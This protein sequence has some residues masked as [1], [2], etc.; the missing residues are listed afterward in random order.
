MVTA[1]DEVMELEKGFW[2]ASA[3]PAF[4]Q[5]AMSDDAISIIEPMGFISKQEA[6]DMSKKGEGWVDLQIHDMNVVEL[7]P[8]CVALAY[9]GEAKGKSSGKPYRGSISSVYV[10]KDGHWKLGMTCHQPWEPKAKH[11]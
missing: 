9:H 4:Y 10:R 7:T 11:A 5:R 3:D 6:V 8:D 1:P 2:A